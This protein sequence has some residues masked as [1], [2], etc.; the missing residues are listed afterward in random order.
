M[1]GPRRELNLG[2]LIFGGILLLVGIYY[3][4]RNTLG[5]ELPDLEWDI[6][7]PIIVIAIGVGIVLSVWRSRTG[8]G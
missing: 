6:I 2:G 4:L 1:T 5:I 3:L 8:P 7:W